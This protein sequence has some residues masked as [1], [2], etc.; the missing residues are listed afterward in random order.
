M[1]N[2]DRP[3]N[4]PPP[5]KDGFDSSKPLGEPPSKRE[6]KK[7]I[8]EKEE[9]DSGVEEKKEKQV[10]K[11]NKVDDQI[12]DVDEG[13]DK[14]SVKEP[15]EKPKSLFD[16]SKQAPVK[17]KPPGKPVNVKNQ[18]GELADLQATKGMMSEQEMKSKMAKGAQTTKSSVSE[19]SKSGTKT[20]KSESKKEE[21]KVDS[22]LGNTQQ[23]AFVSVQG[24]SDMDAESSGIAKSALSETQLQE[25]LEKMIDS[26]MTVET[27]GRTDTTILLDG[28]GEFK[29]VQLTISEFDTAKGQLN[30][31]FE[32]LS[33]VTKEIIDNNKSTLVEKLS[34]KGYN[35]QQFIATTQEATTLVS[36]QSSSKDQE[37]GRQGGGGQQ[38]KEQGDQGQG[39]KR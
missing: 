14:E 33:P 15:K 6:F 1:V 38:G 29:G 25:L 36:T 10:K 11:E 20:E 27:E 24:R 16:L 39:K 22:A 31:K 4:I 7:I 35:V 18:Q 19:E 21:P 12:S 9:S 8:G 30:I 3:I 28:P 34:E 32:N 2:P 5:R 23:T 37:Q 17:P 13:D 26:I